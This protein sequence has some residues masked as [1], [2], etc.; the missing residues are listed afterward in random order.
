MECLF[1]FRFAFVAF[2]PEE[3][4]SAIACIAAASG[5]RQMPSDEGASHNGGGRSIPA[6][7]LSLDV[8]ILSPECFAPTGHSANMR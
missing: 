3:I 4:A 7:Y 1:Q 8:V 5:D 2:L 6:Q